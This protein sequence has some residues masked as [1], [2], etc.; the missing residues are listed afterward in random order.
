MARKLK[1]PEEEIK[2][3]ALQTKRQISEINRLLAPEL[4]GFASEQAV[5]KS[6]SA[7][8][9]E[10]PKHERELFRLKTALAL[11]DLTNLQQSLTE[12]RDLIAGEIRQHLSARSAATAYVKL[13][14]STK[15]RRVG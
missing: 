4:Q 3:V 1:L 8:L 5:A 14:R 9:K 15:N 7:R 11:A 2:L 10:M 12:Y 6:V 13:Q